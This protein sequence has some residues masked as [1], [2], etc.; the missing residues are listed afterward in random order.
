[1]TASLEAVLAAV[2]PCTD[3]DPED[4]FPIAVVEPIPGDVARVCAGCPVRRP[5]LAYALTNAVVGIWAGTNTS[6]RQLLR[7]R[8]GLVPL[9]LPTGPGRTD[10]QP[11]PAEGDAL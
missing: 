6:D 11:A 2:P 10:P 9:G 4:F 5:C 8:H 1:M 7:R 3:L